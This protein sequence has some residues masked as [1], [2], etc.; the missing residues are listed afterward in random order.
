MRNERQRRDRNERVRSENEWN[1]VEEKRKRERKGENE[2]K[3][4]ERERVREQHTNK[5][6]MLRH[7]LYLYMNTTQL[8][9]NNGN[10]DCLSDPFLDLDKRRHVIFSL[11]R[12]WEI[13]CFVSLT[14]KYLPWTTRYWSISIPTLSKKKTRKLEE[15]MNEWR[16]GRERES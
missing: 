3:R 4:R 12:K 7:A 2:R 10:E 8:N 16:R 1:I 9:T 15:R 5:I 11:N 13:P 14:L 6:Q